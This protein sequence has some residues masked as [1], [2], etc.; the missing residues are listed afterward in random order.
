MSPPYAGLAKI[1]QHGFTPQGILREAK[2]ARA[3]Y[4]AVGVDDFPGHLVVL[5]SILEVC[6]HGFIADGEHNIACF[7]VCTRNEPNTELHMETVKQI[8]A[9]NLP[10]CTT[11]ATLCRKSRARKRRSKSPSISVRYIFDGDPASELH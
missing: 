6:E 8:E 5:L 9:L 10:V 7:D 2:F 4:C 11:L 1:A 3:V